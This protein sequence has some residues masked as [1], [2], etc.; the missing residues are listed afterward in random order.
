MFSIAEA[1]TTFLALALEVEAEAEAE[2][3]EA[4]AEAGF[5]CLSQYLSV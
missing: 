5:C 2:A 4:E 3:A 1:L